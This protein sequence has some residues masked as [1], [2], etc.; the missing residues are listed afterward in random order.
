MLN[1]VVENAVAVNNSNNRSE[2][3]SNQNKLMAAL[4]TLV[5]ILVVNLIVGPYL[6]NEVMC[7]LLPACGK[8]R[9]YDTVG[10]SILL[11]LVIPN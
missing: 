3:N 8:A 5:V 6:W 9:W 4:I 2:K 1:H 11:S 10:L 7:H